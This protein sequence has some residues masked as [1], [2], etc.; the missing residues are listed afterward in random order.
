MKPDWSGKVA[1]VGVAD[2]AVGFLP[3]RTPLSLVAQAA[4]EALSEAGLTFQDV[5][6]V[7]AQWG[8]I[9]SSLL[10]AEYLG[11]N[12]R[13]H[14]STSIGGASN[15]GH[16][17][18]AAAAIMA[19][20]CDVALICYGS[21][22]GSDRKEGGVAAPPHD[23]RSPQGLFE[24]PY[25]IMSP[26]GYYALMAQRHMARYGTT[27]EQLAEI[28]VAT[29]KWAALNPK[30]TRRSPMTIQDVLDSPI[31]SSPLH[32]R[33]CCLRTDGGGA[34]VVT[35]VERAR[36]LRRPPVAVLGWSE[37]ATHLYDIS[38]LPDLSGPTGAKQ[39][40]EAAF[41]MADVTR[42]DVDV[43][44]IYDAFT[45]GP[46]M[47]LEDLGFCGKGEGGAFVSGQRTAPGGDFPLNTSGGGLSYCHPGMFGVFL[48]IEAVRQ[49]RGD[50][51][52]RQVPEART[53]L[54][55][56]YGGVLSSHATLI[57]GV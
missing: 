37:L 50:C 7:F 44:E 38:R 40:G 2:S 17:G 5:D 22:F 30:A 49:L 45:I 24:A 26:L 8:D 23:L 14:D 36:S 29:R 4:R 43:V 48:V 16:V 42:D 19:G 52:E 15:V 53:A 13:Y 55:H 57:L 54:C 41:A 12:A 9:M 21:T 1:I 35:S 25:G 10:V 32:S 18:H 3:G 11:I 47:M 6:G 39:S 46:L 27:S 20:L 34:I 31:V 28:A 51:G 33:D 56:G